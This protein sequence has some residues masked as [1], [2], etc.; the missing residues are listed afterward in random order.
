MRGFGMTSSGIG[1]GV[2]PGTR[3]VLLAA[4]HADAWLIPLTVTTTRP[5]PHSC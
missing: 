5:L 1:V 3:Q 4:T 2:L